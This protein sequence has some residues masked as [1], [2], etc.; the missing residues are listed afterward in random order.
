MRTAGGQC[1]GLC[2]RRG[3]PQD[4]DASQRRV[5]LDL[6]QNLLAMQAWQVQV[7]QHQI[8][9]RRRTGIGTQA[10]Q[11]VERILT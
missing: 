1:I 3:E 4:G 8:G 5:G 7:E 2:A 6:S 10:A 11:P 9:Q